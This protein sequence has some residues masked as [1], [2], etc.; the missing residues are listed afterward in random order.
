MLIGR[1]GRVGRLGRQL[2]GHRPPG[3]NLVGGGVGPQRPAVE[4]WPAA[5]LGRAAPPGDP[6]LG[7][8]VGEGPAG[9]GTADAGV[10]GD[11]G[12]GRVGVLAQD[13]E[14]G[15][16]AAGLGAGGHV[17]LPLCGVVPASKTYLDCRQHLKV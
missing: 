6:P 5:C 11:L 10:L 14:D 1:H 7:L 2:P 17:R 8:E 16:D 12:G 4:G 15:L 9:S 3:L 13:I